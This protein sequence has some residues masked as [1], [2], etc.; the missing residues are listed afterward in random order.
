L[1]YWEGAVVKGATKVAIA[2]DHE[3]VR[4]GIKGA[5]L[6]QSDFE[7][8]GEAADGAQVLH[9]IEEHSPAIVILDIALPD[10]NG[11]EL[12]RR[13]RRQ[14]PETRIV[15][16]TMY[17]EQGFF[18]SMFKAGVSGY[19]L[20]GDPLEDLITALRVVRDGDVFYSGKVA[21]MIQGYVTK[22]EKG[23]SEP[24]GLAGLSEREKKVFILLA[25]GRSVK[26]IAFELAISPKT[27]ETYK[28]RL[29]TKLGVHS[30][31]ELTKIAIKEN[32][33]RL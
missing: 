7:V 14:S 1:Y 5:L 12:A 20:K 32:M 33:L 6:S 9:L 17:A 21:P 28:Y 16:Y 29:M 25:E 31:V 27:V 8:V 19:V 3:A 22:L 10:I 30:I 26:E 4:E 13:I 18:L 23:G 24:D 11:I 2:D 15:V